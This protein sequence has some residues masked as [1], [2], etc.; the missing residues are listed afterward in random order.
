MKTQRLTWDRPNVWDRPDDV[1]SS[2][3]LSPMKSMVW[4]MSEMFTPK[5]GPFGPHRDLPRRRLRRKG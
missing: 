1:I 5:G 2:D 3:D 4:T